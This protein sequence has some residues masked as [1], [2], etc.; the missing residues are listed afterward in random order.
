MLRQRPTGMV[1][2]RD[3]MMLGDGILLGITPHIIPGMTPGTILGTILPGIMDG[4]IHGTMATVGVGDTR[5]GIM[6]GMADG[7]IATT[8]DPT[9]IMEKA[10]TAILTPA[11][12]ITD[13]LQVQ[14]TW[15]SA[16][17]V[18]TPMAL[19]PSAAVGL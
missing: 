6:D 16:M 15:A 17:A 11:H 10:I 8:T 12:R 9:I 3:A 4:T 19:A 5:I 7:A 1:M 14:A 2:H 18:R 13:A